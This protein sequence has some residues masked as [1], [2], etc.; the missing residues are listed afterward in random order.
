MAREYIDLLLSLTRQ[1]EGVRPQ[2]VNF[3]GGEMSR[4]RTHRNISQP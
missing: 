2:I 4:A 1:D 3:N